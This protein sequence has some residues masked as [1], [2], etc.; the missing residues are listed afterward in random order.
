MKE[1]VIHSLPPHFLHMQHQSKINIPIFQRLSID[2]IF[3]R[4]EVQEKR[5]TLDGTFERHTIFHGNKLPL[6]ED[7][8]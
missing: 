6:V 2:K 5:A 3:P 8:E 4:A 7:R 1:Q